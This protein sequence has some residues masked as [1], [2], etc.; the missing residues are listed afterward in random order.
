MQI[1]G[2]SKGEKKIVLR[3]LEGGTCLP[4]ILSKSKTVP[5]VSK[6]N[7]FNKA[8]MKISN[9]KLTFLVNLLLLSLNDTLSFT[10]LQ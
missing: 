5:G 10:P 2:V 1:L 3:L 9:N 4:A 8:L 7:K 6:N